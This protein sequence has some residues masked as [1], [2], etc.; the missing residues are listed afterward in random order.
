MIIDDVITAGT[1]IKEAFGIIAEAKGTVCGVVIALDREE[2]TADS[3]K[4][5][6]QAV[7]TNYG[8]PVLSIANLNKIISYLGDR[9][10][11]EELAS[12]E[13]YKKKYGVA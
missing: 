9:L 5:A 10:T 13:E 6:V 8:V 1:A 12:I 7:S 4:S 11:K 3:S 2:R